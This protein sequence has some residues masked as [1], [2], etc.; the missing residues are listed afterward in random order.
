MERQETA[1]KRQG[2]RWKTRHTGNTAVQQ[3][4]S[5]LGAPEEASEM[6]SVAREIAR[7]RVLNVVCCP[8]D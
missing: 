3:G 8:R 5:H 2:E 6:C 1:G 7:N 4:V